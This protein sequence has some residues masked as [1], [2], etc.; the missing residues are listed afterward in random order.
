MTKTKSQ[1]A[2]AVAM[3]GD[4]VRI[5][6]E[7]LEVEGPAKKDYQ[8]QLIQELRAKV[9]D[10]E[11]RAEEDKKDQEKRLAEN[12]VECDVAA[13]R[14]RRFYEVQNRMLE[15]AWKVALQAKDR[16]MG[17]LIKEIEKLK[18]EKRDLERKDQR[19]IDQERKDAE[20]RDRE[21]K[22]GTYSWRGRQT[23]QEWVQEDKKKEK[24][25]A[26]AVEEAVKKVKERSRRE[27]EEME[28]NKVMETPEVVMVEDQ[29]EVVVQELGMPEVV[30]EEGRAVVIAEE[31]R[32]LDEE[33]EES[34]A[35]RQARK[36]KEEKVKEDRRIQEVSRGEAMRKRRERIK[37][38]KKLP[39]SK[40]LISSSS[41]DE[42]GAEKKK[43]KDS[44]KE[45]PEVGNLVVMSEDEFSKDQNGDQFD[46]LFFSD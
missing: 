42:E 15:N 14:W 30:V 12:K 34:R 26:Q 16:E 31:K 11:K 40:A 10:L 36:E 18:H 1:K 8:G 28:K 19:R 27:E 35:K 20:R 3:H 9:T 29:T 43:N 21:R 6:T 25:R 46:D 39:K 38:G 37:E 5:T 41:E 4:G 24:E 13:E 33:E 23:T 44:G 32:K 7:G 45:D 22:R 2:R 17:N